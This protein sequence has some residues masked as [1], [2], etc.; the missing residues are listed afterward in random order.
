[1]CAILASFPGSPSFRAIIPRMTFDPPEGKAEGEP[2]RF[3]HMTSVMLRHPYIRYRRGGQKTFALTAVHPA[4][5]CEATTA[6]EPARS[7]VAELEPC[8]FT[9]TLA[10]DEV[11]P[12]CSSMAPVPL[13]R[14]F[15]RCCFARVRRVNGGQRKGFLF[16]SRSL[17]YTNTET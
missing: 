3:C 17:Q 16:P 10:I 1:M 4:Y 8:Y 11:G 2:G 15:S 9:H 14:L 13:R 6:K 5:A 12:A 7:Q